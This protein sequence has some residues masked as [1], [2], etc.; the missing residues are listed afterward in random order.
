[1]TGVIWVLYRDQ[2][3]PVAVTAGAL[4][5]SG[6]EGTA[7]DGGVGGRSRA[8]PPT[9][10]SGRGVRAAAIGRA[11]SG[12]RTNL[13]GVGELLR[14][15][16]QVGD[17]GKGDAPLKGGRLA[18]RSGVGR[19][20]CSAGRRECAAAAASGPKRRAGGFGQQHAGGSPAWR[21]ASAPAG[22]TQKWT[23]AGGG[24]GR[25]G[26]QGG[27]RLPSGLQQRHAPPA[28]AGGAARPRRSRSLVFGPAGWF[29]N[30][31]NFD[32]R[33]PDAMADAAA[34]SAR[35]CC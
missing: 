20:G 30:A 15:A 7:G 26:C 2:I 24:G 16:L 19:E 23:A 1:L 33:P 5:W 11:R 32:A 28:R 3:T 27:A 13:L 10:P 12:G 14:R 29:R 18:G 35:R 8:A 22:R 6:A 17:V 25:E 21:R 34:Q 9:L 31:V 4:G